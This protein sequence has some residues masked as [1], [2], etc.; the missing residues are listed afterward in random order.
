M[1]VLSE[2]SIRNFRSCRDLSSVRLAD[3]TPIVGYNN[4]GKSN[5]LGA[6]RWLL[7]RSVLE[8]SDFFDP[9]EPLC[10]EAVIAGI[11]AGVLSLLEDRHASRIR[12][13]LDKD[14]LRIRRYQPSPRCG[15][16]D[17]RLK[18]FDPSKSSPDPDAWN[19]N[20][21]GIDNAI[22][23]LF[24]EPID[25]AA[26]DDLTKDIGKYESS[27]TI[28][29]LLAQLMTTL[30]GARG[31]E[32][33]QRID[34]LR[35]VFESDGVHRALEFS[36][37]DDRANS[38]ISEFFP[39][40]AVKVHI[41]APELQMLFKG[42]SLRVFDL[43]SHANG[44]DSL[45][46]DVATLGHGA[47]R[48]IQMSLIKLL[49]DST[50]SSNSGRTLLLVDEPEL[51]MHPQAVVK[52]RSALQKLAAGPYQVV[53]ST[54]S[55]MMI[56]RKDI[57]P[58]V[59]IHKST[60]GETRV[61]RSL[62][63][64]IDAL[65][66]DSGAQI[67]EIFS[68][69]SAAEVLFSNRVILAEGKTERELLPDLFEGCLG[70]PLAHRQVGLVE[71]R[72][73]G[74]IVKCLRVLQAADIPVRALADLDFAFQHAIDAKL[75][76]REDPDLALCLANLADVDS[77]TGSAIH[78]ACKADKRK[79]REE[80]ERMAKSEPT[81]SAIKRLHEKLKN[82]DIWLWTGGAIEQHLGMTCKSREAIEEMRARLRNEGSQAVRDLDEVVACLRWLA[83]E[84]V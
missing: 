84:Q 70:A 40:V 18:V 63:G 23:L 5:I 36:E 82:H 44:P 20:P 75:L 46:R 76:Q 60:S 31:G 74:N 38:I 66:A 22:S 9:S 50:A 62:A 45:G 71:L 53:V 39:G 69:A 32:I 11:D 6:I 73:S 59:M 42:G 26:M 55:P 51:H 13:F 67:D 48:A 56:D 17:I 10:V 24:P 49:A 14:C 8:R 81:L 47:Q 12:P 78:G 2:I 57:G 35:S 61:R 58:T 27:S 16:G 68:M 25:I 52:V 72:G 79:R 3:F 65:E 28:G 37:F 1:Q 83:D 41:P 7:R 80:I 64:A 30:R 15:A 21:T 29:R 54:H 19:D 43:P 34:Q 33:Q 77:K 4:A